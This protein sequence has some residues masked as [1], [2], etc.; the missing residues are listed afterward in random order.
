M[1]TSGNI[2]DNNECSTD[3]RNT[4]KVCFKDKGVDSVEMSLDPKPASTVSWKD[5]LLRKSVESAKEP[6]EDGGEIFDFVEEDFTKFPAVA[7][8]D[9]G[10]EWRPSK[11]FQLIDVEN[12]FFFVKFQRKE[13]YERALNQGP[14]I[15][16]GQYLMVQLWTLDFNPFQPFPLVVMAWIRL[17]GL[18]GYLNNKKKS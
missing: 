13:D 5:M 1:S 16:F 2:E 7:F 8:S 15:V 4:R 17:P 3:S 9:R 6:M 12:G 11:P 14:W 10:L 18:P